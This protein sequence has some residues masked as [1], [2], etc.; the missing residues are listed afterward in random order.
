[1]KRLL[2]QIGITFFTALAAAFYLTDQI[3]FVVM[4]VSAAV[5]IVFFSIRKIRKKLYIPLM[6]LF[7]SVGCL[8]NLSYTTFFVTP[9]IE[10]Y[11]GAHKVVAMLKDEPRQVYDTYQYSLE[12]TSVDSQK[13]HFDMLLTCEDQ[14]DA[15]PFDTLCFDGELEKTK[16]NYLISKGYFLSQ[17]A[18]ALSCQV[19]KNEKKPIWYTA[20]RVRRYFREALNNLL[21]GD[22]AALC[23]A[24][25]LGDKY[26]V[27]EDIRTAFK[28]SGAS[29]FIVVSG[30]HFSFF[31]LLLSFI[32]SRMIRKRYIYI[33]IVVA[34]TLF[35]MAVTGFSFSVVRSGVM[36]IVYL[37]GKLFKRRSDSLNSLG[38][39]GMVLPCF[40][41]PYCAGDIGLILSFYATFSI[42]MWS[43]PIY[44][45]I[46][47]KPKEGAG[48]TKWQKRLNSLLRL[49]SATLAANILVIPISM[50]TFRAFSTATLLSSILL[51]F[52]IEGI[53][54]FS[55]AVCLFCLCPP[56]R[57]IAVF[58][59]WGLY[60]ICEA[61]MFV[62]DTLSRLPFSYVHITEMFVYLWLLLSAVLLLMAF[63]S[64]KGYR[65]V[66]LAVLCS[67][68]MLFSSVTVY[69]V[70]KNDKPTLKVY[71]SDAGMITALE[72]NGEVYLLSLSAP[73][74]ERFRVIREIAESH[75]QIPLAVVDSNR[76]RLTLSKV[77]GREFAISSVL[78]Y[79]KKQNEET[80]QNV[81]FYRGEREIPLSD[82][83]R[84]L[85]Y[86]VGDCV[87][88]RI[89][90]ASATA[91]ILPDRSDVSLLPEELRTADIAVVGEKTLH[92]ELI[93]CDTLV[94][95]AAVPF[96]EIQAS[97]LSE[98]CHRVR[99][100]P[101]N[102]YT[103]V[104]EN[105]YAD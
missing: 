98:N 77:N 99:M 4:L 43:K 91:L 52:L 87:V 28:L 62:V 16:E 104:L 2:A 54:L 49:L 93:S 83:T 39:A 75:P 73:S 100:I 46:R 1:M 36:M 47:I 38:I 3:T 88:R 82:E 14:I 12:V 101:D 13:A 29:Y 72:E 69:A 26:A 76:E 35:Y 105:S 9:V 50:L 68:A 15:D 55:L 31:T 59:S 79:D 42:L 17:R 30:M 92:P 7:V 34:F 27:S 97:V 19:I 102:D 5:A 25:L 66:P 44:E 94:L 89:T 6:A 86:P 41:S 57:F 48:E 71:D 90:T 60:G 33:P 37:G 40:F 10:S 11:E 80:Y 95:T 45:K 65:Y 85:L 81:T 61:V 70:L 96:G 67:L 56:L 8:V 32:L 78:L 20:I 22:D 24:I 64:K 23:R 103:V 58:L 63:L 51:Y 21:P 74:S 84:L 53:L 18:Y